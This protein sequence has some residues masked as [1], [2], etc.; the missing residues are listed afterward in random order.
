MMGFLA[1][2]SLLSAPSLLAQ[3]ASRPIVVEL[4]GPN[5]YERGWYHKAELGDTLPELANRHG[6]ELRY[7]A[8]VNGLKTTSHLV[9][10]SLVYIPPRSGHTHRVAAGETIDSIAK[11]Y[12]LDPDYLAA[13][14]RKTRFA[15]LKTSEQLIIPTRARPLVSVSPS[16][17]GTSGASSTTRSSASSTASRGASAAGQGGKSSVPAAKSSRSTA[18]KPGASATANP[19][20]PQPAP[21]SSGLA[22]LSG[23]D[24]ESSSFRPGGGDVSSSSNRQEETVLRV[25]PRAPPPTPRPTAT[26]RPTRAAPTP[27]PPPPPPSPRRADGRPVFRWPVEGTL[28]RG[29]VNTSD[30]KHLGLDIAA[31]NGTP[32][33]AAADGVVVYSG[34]EI[35]GYGRMVIL[36]HGSGWATCYAHNSANLVRANDRVRAGD[37]IARVGETGRA[38]GPHLHFEVRR[39]QIAVDPLPLLP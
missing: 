37:L 6:V 19:S 11:R 24:A 32:I 14:N 34:D 12:R 31:P 10:G 15:A 7:L 2:L 23:A 26:P 28:T 36:D 16:S 4:R 38:T 33:R 20:T 17:T 3:T 13:T 27:A 30:A 5:R 18:A 9:V 21:S 39:N 1:L 29:F 35:P 8:E 22:Q 25:E